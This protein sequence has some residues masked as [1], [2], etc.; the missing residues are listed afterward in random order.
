MEF[1]YLSFALIVC[2]GLTLQTARQKV[3]PVAGVTLASS[4]LF[5]IITNFGTWATT[6]LYPHSL[7]GL[8]TCYI[9][10]IPFFWNTLAGDLFYSAL[11][12]GGFALLERSIPALREQAR[13]QAAPA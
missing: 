12:F 10:A 9:A 1:Q 8:D 5:F 13:P 3:V 4:V 2:L 11:L 6:S 7:A